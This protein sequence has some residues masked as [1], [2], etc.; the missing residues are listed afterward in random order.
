M[1]LSFWYLAFRWL[2]QLILLRPRSAEFKE[3]EIVVL[4]HQLAVFRRPVQAAMP[5]D[6][7]TARACRPVRAYRTSG[8]CGCS[9]SP[10]AVIA[11]DAS[12]APAGEIAGGGVDTSGSATERVYSS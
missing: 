6:L 3:L 12:G 5:A 2:L 4:R 9:T 1:F 8:I 7:L 10:A 11:G